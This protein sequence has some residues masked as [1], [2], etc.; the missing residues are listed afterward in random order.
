MELRLTYEG[1][2]MGASKGT[3]RASHKH[4]IRRIFHRQLRRFW[5]IEPYLKNA[6]KTRRD[7]NPVNV[8]RPRLVDHLATEYAR[9]G[10]NF[11][12]LVTETLRIHCSVDVLLLRPS[13]PGEVVM[14]S[15][16]IDNRLKTLFD[17]LRMPSNKDELG[18]YDAP[19]E[20]EKPFYCLLTDD[21][22]ITRVSVET[23]RLL[24]PTAPDRGDNDCRLVITVK[25]RPYDMGWD[26]LNFGGG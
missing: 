12:P 8:P 23:D 10:Y 17:S 3:T 13:M 4:D 5:Q 16:D 7:Q 24:E 14:N 6:L 21:R 1:V 22:L 20:D 2:L 11:V 19:T 25:L 9:V 26:N 18:G 15:G